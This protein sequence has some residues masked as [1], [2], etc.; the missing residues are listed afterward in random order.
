MRCADRRDLGEETY[1][2]FSFDGPEGDLLLRAIF[3]G[4]DL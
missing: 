3:D 2:Y 1:S 4:M